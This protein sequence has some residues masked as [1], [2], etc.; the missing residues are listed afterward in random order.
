ML[1]EDNLETTWIIG[2]GIG[3][4]NMPVVLKDLSLEWQFRLLWSGDACK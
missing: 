4:G 3:P 1:Y 2:L